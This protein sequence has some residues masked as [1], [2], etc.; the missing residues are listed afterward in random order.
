[1]SHDQWQEDVAFGERMEKAK[2]FG[3]VMLAVSGDLP[4]MRKLRA[5]A[6]KKRRAGVDVSIFLVDHELRVHIPAKDYDA[7]FT[8]ENADDAA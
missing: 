6:H 5:Y 3:M 4:L 8:M 2:S 7:P 1:M